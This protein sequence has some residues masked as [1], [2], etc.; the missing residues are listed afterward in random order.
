MLYW[1]GLVQII[2]YLVAIPILRTLYSDVVVDYVWPLVVLF[3]GAYIIAGFG[4]SI[5]FR[6]IKK[7]NNPIDLQIS[8]FGK[9]FLFFWIGLCIVISVQYGLYNR[10][11]GTENAAEL[12]ASLPLVVLFSF[13]T[14]E[15]SLPML[16]AAFVINIFDGGRHKLVDSCLMAILI[17]TFFLM[18]AASSRIATGIFLMTILVISQNRIS[19]RS[20]RRLFGSFVVM[21]ALLFIM[22]TSFRMIS[23]VGRDFSE[24]LNEEL[25]RRLDGLEVVSDIVSLYGY[26][27]FGINFSAS[28][29]PLT[30]LLPFSDEATQLKMDAMTSVK[31]YVLANE[32][33]STQRD[34]NSFIIMDVYYLTGLFGVFFVGLAIGLIARCVDN[35]IGL[36]TRPFVFV[37]IIAIAMNLMILEREMLGIIFFMMRDFIILL[38]VFSLV[39]ER[40]NWYGAADYDAQVPVTLVD[41]NMT[42]EAGRLG[43]P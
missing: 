11:I 21:G 13:R 23:D 42:T 33:G 1:F 10:R 5:F 40:R 20:L 34:I 4:F 31:A 16:V 26:Q 27:L 36:N 28:V 15:I 2:V 3:L 22:V 39:F 9:L 7:Y 12:F 30:A 25:I 8:T 41:D 38:V 37:G 17:A 18:G 6:T 29:D 14:L 32:F 24:Y 19:Y 43:K 35:V